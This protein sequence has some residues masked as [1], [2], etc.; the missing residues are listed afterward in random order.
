MN[1]MNETMDS[2]DCSESKAVG[3]F[4][5]A[6]CTFNLDDTDKADLPSN[7]YSLCEKGKVLSRRGRTIVHIKRE[8]F[9]RYTLG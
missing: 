4:F 7:L 6:A 1:I 3:N 9:Y 2:W 5:K 8:R